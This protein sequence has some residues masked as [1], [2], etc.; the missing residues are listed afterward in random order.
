MSGLINVKAIETLLGFAQIEDGFNLLQENGVNYMLLI[1]EF[2][3]IGVI[4]IGISI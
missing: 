3:N 1:L 4:I 2:F